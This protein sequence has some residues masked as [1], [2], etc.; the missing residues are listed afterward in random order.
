[1]EDSNKPSQ[2][3]QSSNK[4]NRKKKVVDR[5]GPSNTALFMACLF[6]ASFLWL[7]VRLSGVYSG[8]VTAHLRYINMPDNKVM[9]KGL[10]TKLKLYVETTGFKLLLAKFGFS[11]TVLDIDYDDYR[12]TSYVL[13]EDL[14]KKFA[15]N[16]P[17]EIKLKDIKPDTLFLYF[18]ERVTKTVPIRLLW[19]IAFQKQYGMKDSIII[20]PDSV[21]LTGPKSL[22][23][24]I[25]SWPTKKLKMKDVKS[26]MD[27]Q[28]DLAKGPEVIDLNAKKVN[29]HAAIEEYTEQTVEVEVRLTNLPNNMDI[30]T[31]PKKV[32]VTFQVPLS[33]YQ[34]VSDDAFEVVA[35]FTNVD[36][37]AQQKV[38][39]ELNKA[40]A[41]V[42]N[43]SLSPTA[44]EYI[45]YDK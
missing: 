13:T 34:T 8:T 1:M 10:D 20:S 22:L 39:V 4:P 38:Y 21:K 29:Y 28:I 19:D 26:D 7:M 18:D 41:N 45:I 5:R 24:T 12:Y 9:V 33:S 14:K 11:R 35:N 23:D 3:E 44:V 27:G 17:N 42:K 43:V 15:D 32:A 40:P 30:T 36:L 31:Y 25:H 6:V 16:L 2:E 37:S